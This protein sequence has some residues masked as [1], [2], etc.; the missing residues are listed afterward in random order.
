MPINAIETKFKRRAQD[1]VRSFSRLKLDGVDVGLHMLRD[2]EKQPDGI[3]KVVGDNFHQLRK[4]AALIREEDA[5]AVLWH[6]EK[7]QYCFASEMHREAAKAL[8]G[9]PCDTSG[10]Q[11][12]LLPTASVEKEGQSLLVL[13]LNPRRAPSLSIA[14]IPARIF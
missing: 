3:E 5:H 10:M 12:H 4:I 9:E 8:L 7:E 2:L 11:T 13:P 6:P 14:Q 1:E